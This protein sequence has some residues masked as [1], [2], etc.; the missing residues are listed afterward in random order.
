[1][2][3]SS[4]WIALHKGGR[5][6]GQAP[7]SGSGGGGSSGG[8]GGG[9]GGGGGGGDVGG[10]G[11]DAKIK[12]LGMKKRTDGGRRGRGRGGGRGGKGGARREKND[13]NK[14]P[15]NPPGWPDQTNVRDRPH[16]SILLNDEQEYCFCTNFVRTSKVGLN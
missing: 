6:E 8:G 1:M 16:R 4:P 9:E 13:T 5:G 7:G 12:L 15:S 10:G 11:L 2:V 3:E 14:P